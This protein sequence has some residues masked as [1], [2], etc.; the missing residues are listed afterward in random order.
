MFKVWDENLSNQRQTAAKLIMNTLELIAQQWK[1]DLAKGL[2]G[3]DTHFEE[4]I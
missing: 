2:S 1:W 4:A 3:Q